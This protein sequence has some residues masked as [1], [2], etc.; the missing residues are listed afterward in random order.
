MADGGTNGEFSFY[1]TDREGRDVTA[2]MRDKRKSLLCRGEGIALGVDGGLL[3]WIFL[4]EVV[5]DLDGLIR[6]AV[7]VEDGREAGDGFKLVGESWLARL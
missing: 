3:A 6:L 4:G 5:E 2:V 1:A 7:L